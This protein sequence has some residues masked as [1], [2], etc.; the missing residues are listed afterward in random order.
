MSSR[1]LTA[2]AKRGLV[3]PPPPHTAEQLGALAGAMFI[4]P[5]RLGRRSPREEGYLAAARRLTLA[6]PEGELAAWQWGPADGPRVG[7]VHGWEGHGAQLGA[8]AAPL[9]EAGFCVVSFDAPGHGESQGEQA[10]VPMLARVLAGL[11][12]S[13]G[14]FFALIGHSMGAAAAALST[15]HGARPAGLVLLAPP[16]S[17]LDRLRRIARRLELDAGSSTA[18]FAEVE[19]LTA[20]R[21]EEADMLVVARAAPCPLLVFH[22]P[23]DEDT[24]FA[25]TERIVAQWSGARLVPCPGR[26]HYRIMATPEI[27]RQAVDFIAGLPRT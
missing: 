19:R 24:G 8:F 11:D 27:V 12:Q 4:R 9:A 22:D 10:H 21:P 3:P 17:Q 23:A 25:D 18:F 20:A 14:P 5:Q 26:G 7:L 1:L 15:R 13:A 16:V 6:T 2:A